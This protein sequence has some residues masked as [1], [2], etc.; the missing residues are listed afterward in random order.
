MAIE[1][2]NHLSEIC[3]KIET[4]MEEYNINIIDACILFCEQNNTDIESIGDVI[5]NNSKL[6]AIAMNEAN[7]LN[8]IRKK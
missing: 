1:I 5:K 8:F 6:K 3:K 2:D 4:I 7:E